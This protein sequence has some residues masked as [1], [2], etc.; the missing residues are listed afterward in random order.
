MELVKRTDKF[1]KR[2][3][4]VSYILI[5]I[6][7]LMHSPFSSELKINSD[8]RQNGAFSYVNSIKIKFLLPVILKKLIV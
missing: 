7:H 1:K 5:L 4:I 8:I 6:A 2:L 3:I